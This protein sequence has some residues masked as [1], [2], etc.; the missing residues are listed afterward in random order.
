M[1]TQ[2]GFNPNHR[3]VCRGAIWRPGW[4]WPRA[5]RLVRFVPSNEY[6]WY[7]GAGRVSWPEQVRLHSFIHCRSAGLLESSRLR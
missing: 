4:R 1:F 2:A 6:G 7:G 3:V 5:A